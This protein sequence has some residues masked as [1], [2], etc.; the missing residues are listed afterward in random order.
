[1]L[2][3]AVTAL[4]DYMHY[5]AGKYDERLLLNLT[6]TLYFCAHR[7]FFIILQHVTIRI[8]F[9]YKATFVDNLVQCVTFMFLIY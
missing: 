2:L 1:M 7:F 8:R 5:S 3:Y 4:Q 6:K 9:V